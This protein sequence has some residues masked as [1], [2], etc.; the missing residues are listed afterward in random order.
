MLIIQ[1]YAIVGHEVIHV[2]FMIS[3]IITII[4]ENK[5]SPL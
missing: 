1:N 5:Y 3:Q 4:Q 2:L